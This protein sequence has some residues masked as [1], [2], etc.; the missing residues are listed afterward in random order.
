MNTVKRGYFCSDSQFFAPLYFCLSIHYNFDDKAPDPQGAR[1]QGYISALKVHLRDKSQLDYIIKQIEDGKLESYMGKLNYPTV[2]HI[3]KLI[4]DI[5]QQKKIND[6]SQA[7]LERTYNRSDTDFIDKLKVKAS[8]VPK[9][10]Y[11]N[12]DKE[13]YA[14][15]GHTYMDSYI[16]GIS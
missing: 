1:W 2:R 4:L 6:N 9:G 11:N 12:F 15:E 7:L 13:R 14:K 5:K 8:K 16:T 10:A 3:I